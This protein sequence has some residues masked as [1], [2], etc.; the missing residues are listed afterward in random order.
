VSSGH[1]RAQESFGVRL[2]AATRERLATIP[3]QT[4]NQDEQ[5]YSNYIG[6]YSKGLPHNSIGEVNTSAYRTFLSAVNIGTWEAFERIPL[7]GNTLLVNPLGASLSTSRA[8][9]R[10]NWRFPPRC[11]WR[12]RRAPTRWSNSIGRRCCVT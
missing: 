5:L 7:G 9:I 3:Q 4:P 1:F 12:A 8:P 2:E 11:R 10:T 6:N